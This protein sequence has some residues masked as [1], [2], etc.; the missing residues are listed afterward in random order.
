MPSTT[1]A[2]K[3]IAFESIRTVPFTRIHGRSSRSNYEILKHEATTLASKVD[4]ITYA[5]SCD[6]VTWDKYGLL[7]KILGLNEYIHQ[8]GIDTYVEEAELD[9]YDL[10]IT[11]AIPT[12]TRKRLKEEWECTLTCWYIRKGFL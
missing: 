12:H 5:W 4:D 9:T 10:A 11:V 2:T 6:A 7:A 3:T 8:T 1:R